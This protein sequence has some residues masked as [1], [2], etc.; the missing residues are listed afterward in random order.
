M[1]YEQDRLKE[2]NE[3]LNKNISL[4]LAGVFALIGVAVFFFYGFAYVELSTLPYML[5]YVGACALVYFS[6]KTFNILRV[7]V[8]T[9]VAGLILTVSLMKINWQKSYYESKEPFMFL[10]H[11]DDYPSWEE[12]MIAPL[13][14]APNWV[15]FASEC[16]KPAQEGEGYREDCKSL[17]TIKRRYNLD[18]NAE[19]DEYLARMRHT[20]SLVQRRGSL[21]APQYTNCIYKR[22]CAEIPVLPQDVKPEDIDPENQQHVY[23]TKAYWDLVEGKPLSPEI[24]SFITLCKVLRTTG[25]ISFE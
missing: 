8:M 14:G 12:N 9:V 19:L 3:A 10:A 13:T 5:V 7:L 11:I 25:A 20:A 16:G 6:L 22:E 18:M 24:C 23:I 4:V 1:S 17:V 2:A 15:K 21:T